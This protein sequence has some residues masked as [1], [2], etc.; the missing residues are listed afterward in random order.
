MLVPDS[1]APQSPATEHWIRQSADYEAPGYAF[2]LIQGATVR[3][4]PASWHG[5]CRI[6]TG[7]HHS[8][9]SLIA[10]GCRSR[11][12][13]EFERTVCELYRTL[14][15]LLSDERRHAVRVWNFVPGINEPVAPRL[16]RYMIFNAGRHAAYSDWSPDDLSRWAPA[17][18]GVGSADTLAVHCLAADLP[19]VPI[20]NPRQIP[21]YRYSRRYGPKPPCFARATIVSRPGCDVLLVSGTASI[22]GEDSVHQGSLAGQLEVT[23]EN[24]RAL[25][26]AA[27][28]R[29]ARVAPLTDARVYLPPPADPAFVLEQTRLAFPS[30]VRVE[31]LRAAL[32]RPELLVEI[33]AASWPRPQLLDSGRSRN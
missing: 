14:R 6:A 28:A 26:S 23:F 2:D 15:Q 22:V 3:A 12:A 11:G 32:C 21:A 17:A 1:A 30:L 24:L 20:E 33:E 29:D 25:W 7:Q 18:S 13:G 31:V 9:I 16:D 19:G 10:D 8:L 4:R 5:E 27:H